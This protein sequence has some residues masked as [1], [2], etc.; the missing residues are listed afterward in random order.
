M[1]LFANPE[2]IARKFER[3]QNGFE[4]DVNSELIKLK[5]PIHFG[6]M[7]DPFSTNKSTAI[8]IKILEILSELQYPIVLSTKQ[9]NVFENSNVQDILNK[10]KNLIIQISISSLDKKFLRKIEPNAPTPQH[11]L[12]AIK[13]LSSLGIPIIARIQPF[14]PWRTSEVQKELIPALGENGVNHSIVEFIKLPVEESLFPAADFSNEIG[15]DI[16]KYFLTNNAVNMSREWIFL[17]QHKWELLQ[18]IIQAI[19]DNQ[20]TYGAGDY[21]VNHL[22]DTDCCCGLDKFKGF[23]GYFKSF[24]SIIKKKNSDELFFSDVMKIDYPK[25]SLKM[26]LNSNCRID[27]FNTII[28]LLRVKWNSPGS[29]NAPD[30]FLGISYSGKR[31]EFNDCIYLKGSI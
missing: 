8:S 10:N 7:S 27:G 11:R 25:K 29:V 20:M 18:P 5:M 23:D 31:D 3:V 13:G 22:G 30:T 2:I 17:T 24:T 16:K 19:R 12:N 26:Y 14:F 28:N 1:N 6:G 21:G 9:T 4:G 15:F